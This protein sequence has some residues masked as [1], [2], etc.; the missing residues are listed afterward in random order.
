MNEHEK[1]PWNECNTHKMNQDGV[2]L[3]RRTSGGGAV[4]HD[5][6]NANYAITTPLAQFHRDT[7][8]RLVSRAINTL[9][10]TSTINARHDIIIDDRKI[11]Y[12]EFFVNDLSIHYTSREVH[13][14]W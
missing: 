10:F 6:G 14:N 3:V 5:T 2:H 13:S 9:G 4:Y 7:C 1:I 12:F 8:P 11:N